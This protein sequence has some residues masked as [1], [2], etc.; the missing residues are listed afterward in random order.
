[1]LILYMFFEVALSRKFLPTFLALDLIAF[2]PDVQLKVV[3]V[4]VAAGFRVANEAFEHAVA[5]VDFVRVSHFRRIFPFILLPVVIIDVTHQSQF[6]GKS[7]IT[8]MTN[9]FPR[10]DMRLFYVRP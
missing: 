3:G 5:Q 4:P 6:R 8:Q 2:Q 1:M 10:V 9:V 7:P